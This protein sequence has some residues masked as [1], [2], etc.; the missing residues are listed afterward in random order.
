MKLTGRRLTLIPITKEEKEEFY[1]LATQSYG[2]QFWYDTSQKINK[3]RENF[4]EDWTDVYFDSTN[5]TDGQCF[6]IVVDDKKIGQVNSNEIDK[7]NKR[8]E[9]DIIIGR[10]EYLDQGYGPEALEILISYLF[11]NFDLNKVW[12][13]SRNN[14]PRAMNAYKK[15][16]FKQEGLLRQQDYFE[17]KFVDC[18]SFG[19]LK[20][21]FE[22]HRSN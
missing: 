14:N 21:E 7:E 22:K 13:Q 18:T 6:W 8:V 10:K 15:V 4:F 11:D 1:Q 3:T 5:I 9:L 20:G 2:S 12:I 19:L 17:G 16:G